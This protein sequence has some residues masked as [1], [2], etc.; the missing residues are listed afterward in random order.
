MTLCSIC[1]I[2]HQVESEP[3]DDMLMST[4]WGML[5][6]GAHAVRIESTRLRLSSFPSSFF[7][8]IHISFLSRSYI[9]T[10]AV[11]VL[12][13]RSCPI[14]YEADT[15]AQT[16]LRTSAAAASYSAGPRVAQR[17]SVKGCSSDEALAALV[18]LLPVRLSSTSIYIPHPAFLFLSSCLTLLIL[19]WIYRCHISS[20]D[21]YIRYRRFQRCLDRHDSGHYRYQAPRAL[22]LAAL[23]HCPAGREGCL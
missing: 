14:V 11:T 7:L 16:G 3:H 8:P 22:W 2:K 20:L 18:L 21:R 1:R 5:V 12:P 17:L 10:P 13:S 19:F 23:A 15:R 9:R 6:A 4:M